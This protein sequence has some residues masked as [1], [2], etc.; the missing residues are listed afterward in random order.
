M[1]AIETARG[2]P[3]R[4]GAVATAAQ[5][6]ALCD[7]QARSRLAWARLFERFDVVIAPPASTVAFAHDARPFD[8]RTI[9]IDGVTAPYDAQIAWAGIATWPGLPATCVPVTRDADGMPIGVQVIGAAFDD[10]LTIA[11]ADRIASTLG[12]RP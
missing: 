7:R 5:W 9:E 8:E 6:L 10:R 1:L 11:V 3:S 12:S 2:A 4:S